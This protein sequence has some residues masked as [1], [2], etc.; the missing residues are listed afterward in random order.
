MHMYTYTGYWVFDSLVFKAVCSREDPAGVNENPSTP[1][2]V[3]FETSL[4]N[5][6]DRLPWL[7]CDV[8]ISATKHPKSSAIQ[9]VVQTL[10]TCCFEEKYKKH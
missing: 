7:F 5:I 9:G 8:T 6:N 2:E 4:V 3:S 1:V 10:A